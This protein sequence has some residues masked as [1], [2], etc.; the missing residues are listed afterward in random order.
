MEQII[1]GID[2]GSHR[3]GIGCILKHGSDTKLIT[4][5][6]LHAPKDGALYERLSSIQQQ[7]ESALDKLKPSAVALE[8]IFFAKNARSAFQIGVARGMVFSL[9]IRRSI[10]VF[11]YA[12][13]K[14]KQIVTGSGRADKEQVKK[15]VG[16]LLGT[17]ENW[18]LDASDALAIAICHASHGKLKALLS[19]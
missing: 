5:D 15:M 8:D 9:C 10:P 17:K 6:T 11:E 18:G 1:L 12:P 7:L 13:T 19:C 4:A 3:L 2:P 16:I 14:V